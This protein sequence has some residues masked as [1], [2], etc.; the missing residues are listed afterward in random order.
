MT[1]T[2]AQALA[3]YAREERSQARADALA[4]LGADLGTIILSLAE[5]VDGVLRLSPDHLDEVR[6]EYHHL[7]DSIWAEVVKSALAQIRRREPI[8]LLPL[9]A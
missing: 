3:A 7:D 4:E 1:H 5:R 6:A 9:D 2:P 8:H